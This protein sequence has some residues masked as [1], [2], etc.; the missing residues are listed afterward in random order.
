MNHQIS[1]EDQFSGF[2]K[3]PVDKR[4]QKV[5]ERVPNLDVELLKSGG[6]S[7]NQADLMI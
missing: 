3:L 1:V 2:Y 4:V 6:L 5:Q 7:L